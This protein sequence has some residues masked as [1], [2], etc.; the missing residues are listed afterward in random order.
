MDTLKSIPNV[1]QA[2]EIAAQRL[3][4]TISGIRRYGWQQKSAGCAVIGSDHLKRWL[5]VQSRPKTRLP[6]KIWFGEPDAA[7][8]VGVKKPKL[9]VSVE[10]E[11]HEWIWRG[12]LMSFIDDPVCSLTPEIQRPLILKPSW[13]KM[14]RTSL[15]N[16]SKNN[17]ERVNTRQ[18][19][20]TRRIR[21]RFGTEIDTQVQTWTTVHGDIHWA[22]LTSSECWILDWEAWGQ[23]PLGLDA[24]FLFCFSLRQ[25]EIAHR[26]YQ[27]FKD[28]L[29]TSDGI[30]S[31]LF[32][33]AELIRMTELYNDHPDLK[34]YIMKYANE[35]LVKVPLK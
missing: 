6:D 31:Q 20:I 18:D 35:L 10:W 15:E 30:R 29:N 24:A 4:K 13:Y 5:R 7:N 3:G 2:L 25:P 9:I 17:T 23:G 28:W 11:D 34:P 22:N 21:E 32:A 26:V 1:D 19:L 27:Y 16:L 8:I 12:D 33:C 14:L